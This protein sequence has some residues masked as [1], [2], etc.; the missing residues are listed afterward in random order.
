MADTLTDLIMSTPVQDYAGYADLL[1]AMT[2]HFEAD[3][4]ALYLLAEKSKGGGIDGEIVE[5]VITAAEKASFAASYVS[6]AADN[7]RQLSDD[8]PDFSKVG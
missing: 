2:K 5:L 8:A 3:R 4:E 1:D 7:A 6:T